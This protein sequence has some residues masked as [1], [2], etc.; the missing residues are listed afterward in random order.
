MAARRGGATSST[1]MPR[2]FAAP[3][4]E[5]RRVRAVAATGAATGSRP[6]A[7]PGAPRAVVIATGACDRPRRA[8]LAAGA[9]RRHPPGRPRRLPAARPSCPTAACWWSAARRPGVQLADEIHAL[10]PAGDA[11]RRPAY[12]HAAPLPRPRHLRLA[13]RG[14]HHRTSAGDRIADL[15]AARRQPSMQ[16]SGRGPLD[17]AAA[18]RGSAS[19][20]SAGSKPS[21]ART[22]ATRRRPRRATAPR[23]T[24]GCSRLL[25]RIDAHIA[26]ARHR[27]AARPGG[28]ASRPRTRRGAA[29]PP[30]PARRGHPHR[31]LGHRLPP[32]LP[33]G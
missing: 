3:V 22:V 13:R 10:R 2:R 25:A 7:A 31:D 26:A 8:G 17:L 24:R 33:A 12:P 1:P 14:R 9:R 30:R 18:R 11:R 27:C 23:P 4:V 32:R 29:A 19:G 6:T 20:S 21:T 28:L 16:L 15:D 5:R